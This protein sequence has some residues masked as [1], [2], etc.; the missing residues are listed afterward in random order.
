MLLQVLVDVDGRPLEVTVSRS[1]GH[2][3][4]D[5]AARLQVGFMPEQVAL[6]MRRRRLTVRGEARVWQLDEMRMARLELVGHASAR[7]LHQR[8]E[9]GGP[10][11]ELLA[12][13]GPAAGADRG[14]PCGWRL[15]LQQALN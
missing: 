9:L 10:G 12:R 14:D 6:C 13:L 4:L 1:S 2:R 5:E 7:G 15:A 3:E 8:L 11:G